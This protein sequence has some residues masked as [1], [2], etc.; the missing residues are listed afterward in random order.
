MRT[1]KR[2]LLNNTLPNGG[3]ESDGVAQAI[4]Q[5]RNTPLR[6][7]DKSP[8]QLAIGRQLRDSVPMVKS[9][10][11]INEHW[12]DTLAAREEERRTAI[13]HVSNKYNERAKSLPHLHAGEKVA[14]QDV[15]TKA[16]DRSGTV[17]EYRPQYR[18]YTIRLDGSGRISIRN[19][20]H[21]RS[22]PNTSHHRDTSTTTRVA[23]E[24][25]DDPPATTRERGCRTR[26]PPQWHSDYIV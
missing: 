23:E 4:L 26:R 16:W 7:I 11:R 20:K 10:H 18:Q 2:T 22:L 12:A 24:I 21:L 19:R 25:V 14:V 5:Y 13:E 1:A 6:G 8:A 15:V 9:Y 3:L 17:I